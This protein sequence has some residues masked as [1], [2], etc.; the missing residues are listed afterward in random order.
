LWKCRAL[1]HTIELMGVNKN[2]T[3]MQNTVF[4]KKIHP[5]IDSEGLEDIFKTAFG[6]VKSA[7]VS[8][9]VK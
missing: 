9:T 6:P 7:K 2:G 8:M 5:E 1:P 4:V 3:N